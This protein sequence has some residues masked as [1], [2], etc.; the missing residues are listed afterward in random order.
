MFLW[1]HDTVEVAGT[2]GVS[3]GCHESTDYNLAT[4]TLA[5]LASCSIEIIMLSVHRV[6]L[7]VM[8]GASKAW[9]NSTSLLTFL[10]VRH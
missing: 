10:L 9:L 4:E 6:S 7:D 2:R 5:S 1:T 3:K 8:Q